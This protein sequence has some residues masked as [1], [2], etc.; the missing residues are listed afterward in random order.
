VGCAFLCFFPLSPTVAHSGCLC[1][2]LGVR[3]FILGQAWAEG[4]G[5]LATCSHRVISRRE[6]RIKNVRRH[7]LNRLH[8]SM[9]KQK[10][11]AQHIALPSRETTDSSPSYCLRDPPPVV[12]LAPLT[13][14]LRISI[15]SAVPVV[16]LSRLRP[17]R[18]DPQSLPPPDIIKGSRA[19][20]INHNR[21]TITR[22]RRTVA[23][24]NRTTIAERK[25]RTVA[26]RNC[27]TMNNNCII[28]QSIRTR[29]N[30]S[31]G[32]DIRSDSRIV[33]LPRGNRGI[34]QSN[35]RIVRS[36]RGASQRDRNPPKEPK[37][38]P[39]LLFLVPTPSASY[40]SLVPST[41]KPGKW[42]APTLRWARDYPP[43]WLAPGRR[44]NG[45][46]C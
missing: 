36:K 45:Q 46:C 3:R 2:F 27:R 29:I 11:S 1:S 10:S 8:A 5:E 38:R 43:L 20:T 17:I 4:K 22:N 30:Q 6:R 40:P 35:R 21:R 7:S 14:S 39:P 19:T 44:Q 25:R 23:E 37:N 18:L 31:G 12:P 13:G 15:L 41:R 24:R 28:F 33:K 26:E 9:N 42:S 32:S 34:D 16:L